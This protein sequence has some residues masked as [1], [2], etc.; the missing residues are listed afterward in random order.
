[1][2]LQFRLS[3]FGYLERIVQSVKHE[4]KNCQVSDMSKLQTQSPEL[5]IVA[6]FTE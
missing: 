5:R 2:Y 3:V 6:K 4:Y 1:M